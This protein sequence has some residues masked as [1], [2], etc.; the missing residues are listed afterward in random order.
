MSFLSARVARARL[1]ASAAATQRVRE[2]RAAGVD[3]V[4]LTQGEP[5]FNT[6]D[7]IIEAAYRAMHAGQTHYTPVDGTPELKAAIVEKFHRDVL[8]PAFDP[9]L[10]VE[11]LDD[12]SLQLGRS[13]DRRVVRLPRVHRAVRGLDD[14]IRRVEIGLTLRQS[15]DVHAGGAQLANALCRRRGGGEP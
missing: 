3:I 11:F 15:H 7:H 8:R 9:V 2:L 13:V 6:P 12:R 4:A 10:A 5:D 14:V 1:T